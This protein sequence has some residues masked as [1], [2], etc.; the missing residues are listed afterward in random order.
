P[1]SNV[2]V[3]PLSADLIEFN[4]SVSLFCSSSGSSLSFL[5]MK[6]NSQVTASDRGKHSERVSNVKVTQ[7][8]THLIEFSGS[9]S[10]SCSSN[11][12][13]LSFLWMNSSSQ[14]TTRSS[15]LSPGAIAGIKTSGGNRRDNGVSSNEEVTYAD[16]R[17]SK[18][19]KP[20]QAQGDV[21]TVERFQPHSAIWR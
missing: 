9:V 16:V 11:G 13:S 18:N 8:L 15:T 12:S 1:V 17:F 6:D 19:K 2:R 20:V 21:T 4:S 5:W 14:I 10:F 3:S 7:D